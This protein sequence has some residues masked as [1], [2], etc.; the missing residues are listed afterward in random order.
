[1]I[2][3]QEQFYEQSSS[4]GSFS[5]MGFGARGK[6]LG[7]SISAVTEGELNV[8]YN[9]SL[10]VF[11]KGNSFSASYS[12]LS[13][14]RKLNFIS[15]TKKFEFGRKADS[16]NSKRFRPTAGLSFGLINSGTNNIDERDNQGFKVGNLSVSENQYFLNLALKISQ[17]FSIGFNAK[18]YQANLYKS[19]TSTTLGFD[20][21]MLYAFN[22]DLNF[23]LVIKDLNSKY[24]WDSSKIYGLDG[25]TLEEKF[26]QLNKIS[27][28]Y[29]LR[30]F[31][32]L[33]AAEFESSSLGTK[34]IKIG[35]EYSLYQS[36]TLRGGMDYIN[37]SNFDVPA[38]PTFGFEYTQLLGGFIIGVNYAFCFEPYSDLDQHIIGINI[39]F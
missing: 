22:E 5:R 13:L 37:I 8:Y 32:L 17:K 39:N 36:F 9:P 12:V 27:A 25:R 24:K 19:M 20:F 2:L 26:P 29:Y 14:D 33:L 30:N 35:G 3:S 1:M 7:N 21:G 6:A 38:R 18:F 31:N 16:I 23:A 28:S 11:Q 10:S 34:T 15:F 4:A